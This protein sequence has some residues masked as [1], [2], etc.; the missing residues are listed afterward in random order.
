MNKCELE[1]WRADITEAV[2]SS[3]AEINTISSKDD[4]KNNCEFRTTLT[5]LAD[6]LNQCKLRFGAK[7]YFVVCLGAVKAGKSTLLNALTGKLVSPAGAGVE[8]TKHCSIILSAD[9]KH[10]E[11]ITVYRTSKKIGINKTDKTTKEDQIKQQQEV[12]KYIEP[13]LDYFQATKTWDELKDEFERLSKPYN[14]HL[15]KEILT[16]EN[17]A[18][19][20]QF[21]D[22]CLAEIRVDVPENSLLNQGVA[23]IDMPGIDGLL[24]GVDANPMLAELPKQCQHLLWVQSTVSALN[25]TVYKNL[26]SF[27]ASKDENIPVYCIL[28]TIKA[29]SEWH[30]PTSV[31][32]EL[33]DLINRLKG[34]LTDTGKRKIADFDINAAMAWDSCEYEKVHNELLPGHDAKTLRK[35]SKIDD[36]QTAI[37]N[38]VA[39]HGEKILL[40]D[41]LHGLKKLCENIQTPDNQSLTEK[42]EFIIFK[43]N[44]EKCSEK[45]KN[46]KHSQEVLKNKY[47]KEIDSCIQKH[48]ENIKNAVEIKYKTILAGLLDAVDADNIGVG[49]V[50]RGREGNFDQD[51]QHDFLRNWIK[52]KD[53]DFSSIIKNNFQPFFAE[54]VDYVASEFDTFKNDLENIKVDI[55]SEFEDTVSF[56]KTIERVN[57]D[58]SIIKNT[59]EL[60]IFSSSTGEIPSITSMS[61]YFEKQDFQVDTSLTKKIVTVGLYKKRTKTE[62]ERYANT[63]LKEYVGE[64]KNQLARTIE[65]L[66]TINSTKNFDSKAQEINSNVEKY[67]SSEINSLIEKISIYGK[68]VNA[69]KK[70]QDDVKRELFDKCKDFE[71]ELERK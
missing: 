33:K 65:N 43:E 4:F 32:K 42:H 22:F 58:R 39:E 28:N 7:K 1:K 52:N 62:I 9:D 46:R 67:F 8:T 63:L 60:V 69:V 13:L 18:C 14:E 30:T 31:D 20:N 38:V 35:I 36:L 54:I 50:T 23:F 47:L 26:Q 64:L 45:D 27:I 24:A 48:Q 40:K 16:T 66:L 57:I 19:L 34:R 2:N 25:N 70:I 5:N 17:P 68:I 49:D 53:K 71:F 55:Q 61:K 12:R 6:E 3:V 51:T 56:K 21:Y 37:A 41:A 44:I 10:P 11:G 59:L 15:L 29:K